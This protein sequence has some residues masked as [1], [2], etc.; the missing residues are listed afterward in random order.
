V[1]RLYRW[2]SALGDVKAASRGPGAYGRRWFRRK[3]H[4]GL[5]K[6]LRQ[7]RWTRP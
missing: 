1:R 2:L 7:S 5:A 3:A 4:K 6:T